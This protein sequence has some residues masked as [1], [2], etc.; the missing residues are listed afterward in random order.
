MT[1]IVNALEEGITASSL[2]GAIPQVGSALV[3]II[4]FS[5][6][7]VIFRRFLR[8]ASKGKARL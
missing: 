6:G 7:F 4:L 5:L 3:A 1:G 8:G 2:T